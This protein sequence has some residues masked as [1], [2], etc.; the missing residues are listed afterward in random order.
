MA[1]GIV[2]FAFLG[3][4]GMMPIG[5]GNFSNAIDA[6]AQSQISQSVF[7]L[8]RQAKFT[9]LPATATYYFDREATPL[10]S[11]GG[12][13]D[14]CIYVANVATYPTAQ[15]QVGVPPATTGTPAISDSM[16]TIS[17]SITRNVGVGKAK[18]VFGY[19]ANNGL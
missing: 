3:L 13:P 11:P 19:V 14:N 18:T 17:V 4:I 10:V 7:A 12:I 2:S 5:L 15:V 9:E 1:L 16:A 8:M 6:T